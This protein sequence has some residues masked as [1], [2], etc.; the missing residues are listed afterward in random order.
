MS[1][2]WPSVHVVDDL[3]DKL[4]IIWIN[5]LAKHPL[6]FYKTSYFEENVRKIKQ[7]MGQVVVAIC[8]HI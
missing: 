5:S 4:T 7:N 6:N 3:L 8:E 2:F 1:L